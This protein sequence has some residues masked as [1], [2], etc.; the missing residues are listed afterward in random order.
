[1]GAGYD[2]NADSYTVLSRVHI[3]LLL[4]EGA[5]FRFGLPTVLDVGWIWIYTV[6]GRSGWAFAML[7]SGCNVYL[8]DFSKSPIWLPFE[9]YRRFKYPLLWK[10]S[11]SGFHWHW[12]YVAVVFIDFGTMLQSFSLTLELRCNG[13][14]WLWNYVAVVFID[15]DTTNDTP[16][17]GVK[18]LHSESTI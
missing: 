2:R 9:V 4:L 1:M 11:C 17:G 10:V 5:S 6:P 3:V 7:Q 15:V 18:V 8:T 16:K 14:H 13:F 12:Q